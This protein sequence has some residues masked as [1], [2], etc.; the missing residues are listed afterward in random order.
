MHFL[1]TC[2]ATIAALGLVRAARVELDWVVGYTTANP[3]GLFERQVIGIN[4][5]WP[6]KQVEATLND[7]LVINIHNELNEPTALHAHGMFQN[8]TNYMDG[9]SMVTQCPIPAGMNFTYEFTIT[10]TGTYWMHSHYGGQ[11]ADG[12]KMALILHNPAEPYKYD[13]DITV[14][15]SDWYHDQSGNNL[16]IFM[17]ENNPTG[18]EPVPESGLIMDNVN[19][20][21]TFVPGKTYRLRLINMSAFSMFYFSI[22]G[23][24]MDVIET[25]GIYTQRTTVKSLYLTAA[26]RISVLVTAKNATNLNYY[27]HADMNTDMFDTI[28]DSLQTNLTAPIYYDKSVTEFAPSED[29]G[30]G[31]DFDDIVIPPLEVMAAVPAEQQLNLTFEFQVYTD[32]I[33]R[34]A[35]NN[36]PYIAPKVPILNTLMTMGNLS[37]EV[38]VYGRHSVPYILD[39]LNM[40]EVIL[41]NADSGDHP[42]HLHGHVFQI[43]ARGPG[44][45]DGTNENITWYLDNPNRRDTV[46]VPAESFTI[47]RFRADNPGIWIFHC[48]IEWHLETGL[49]AIFVEA[50]DIAQQ[51]M[52]LPQ[53]F[54]DLCEA[55]NIPYSGNAA[56]KQGLDLKGAPSGVDI[57]IDGFTA[58]GKGAMAGCILSALLGIGAIV[59]FAHSDPEAR[60]REIIAAKMREEQED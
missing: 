12:F 34:G 4:G 37:H 45:Y 38:D 16:K 2:L 52:T 20:S 24:D 10:Q 25:D 50:P 7:V 39:H 49:A 23:H 60:G 3:D 46:A 6:P 41:N 17:N 27:M 58:S 29:V 19:S 53:A 22:D 44:I 35:F 9:P 57:L 18:A 21:L 54:N 48:H 13:E 55:G 51:R 32:G 43:V 47:I 59:W 1:G 8:N 26:Q 33:N 5:E 42:F 28:S 31:S 56:G 15:I 40:I 11:Y 14:P 36:I 30:M